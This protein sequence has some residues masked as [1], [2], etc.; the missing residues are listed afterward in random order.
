MAE[1][2]G[3]PLL[4]AGDVGGTKTHLGIFTPGQGPRSPLIEEALPSAAYPGLSELVRDFLSRARLKIDRASFGVAGPVVAGRAKI[5]NLPWEISAVSL[6]QELGLASVKL[7]NDLLAMAWSIGQLD[8][9]DLVTINE[10]Q[11]QP[12]GNIAIIAPGTGLGEAF[13]TWNGQGY[14]PHPSEGGHADFAPG[15]P[16]EAELYLTLSRELGHVSYDRICCGSGIPRIYR[17]LVKRNPDRETPSIRHQVAGTADPTPIIIGAAREEKK[18]C[19]LCRESLD[20]FV[21]V[22]GAE[23]G[24]LAL[25]FLATGGVY[26]GGGLPPRILPL[27]KGEAFLKAFEQKGR[28]SYITQQTPLHVITRP[29]VGLLGAAVAGLAADRDSAAF[30]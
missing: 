29:G 23:A 4:L 1:R 18:P 30:S 9:A 7:I 25:K 26:L 17:F 14:E 24:N 28:L 15:T 13:L 21:R 8:R 19:P 12:G 2:K 16:L 6:A 22:L 11:P 27:L 10:G 5:T 3:S 20:I